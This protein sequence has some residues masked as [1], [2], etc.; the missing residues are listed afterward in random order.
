MLSYANKNQTKLP[1]KWTQEQCTELQ[2]YIEWK[3]DWS[4]QQNFQVGCP[5]KIKGENFSFITK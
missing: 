4:F 1:Y 5:L 3:Q 2:P